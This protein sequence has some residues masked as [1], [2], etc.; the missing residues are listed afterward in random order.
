M[1]RK[2]KEA[3]EATR[4]AILDAAAT[5]FLK[6]GVAK[7]GLEEIAKEA[8]VTRGAVYWHFKNKVDIFAALH[9][10]LCV[11]TTE[12]IL[13]ELERNHP[14]PL[15]QLKELCIQLLLDLESKPQKKRAL[16]IFFHKCDYSGEMEPFLTLQKEQKMKSFGIF[17]Q[18]FKRAI[19]KGHLPKEADPEILTR[20]LTCYITG[21]AYDHLRFSELFELNKIAPLLIGN[22]FNG[23]IAN[24]SRTPN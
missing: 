15:E 16:T 9:E 8:G 14:Q 13:Q 19:E 10:Q 7:A 4:D 12:M 11:S 20:M 22:F 6:K 21:I 5:V 23:L 1:A 18:Y 17:S 24:H 3:A 2:T